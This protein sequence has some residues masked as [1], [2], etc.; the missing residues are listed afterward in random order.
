[1]QQARPRYLVVLIALAVGVAQA[2]GRFSYAVLLP[3]EDDCLARVAGRTGHG[4]T[5][6]DA[7]ERHLLREVG[8]PSS[9]A[10]SILDRVGTGVLRYAA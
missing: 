5:D 4:F 1:M 7:T 8:P 2:F 3:P 6:A 10:D 9:F